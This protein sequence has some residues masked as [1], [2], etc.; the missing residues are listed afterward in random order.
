[1]HMLKKLKRKPFRDRHSLYS[2]SF[3]YLFQILS[4]AGKLMCIFVALLEH[5][6]FFANFFLTLFYAELSS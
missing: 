6:P 2:T 3:I 1:M 5:C 4:D